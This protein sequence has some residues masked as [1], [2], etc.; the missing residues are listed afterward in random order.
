LRDRL[1]LGCGADYR[2]EFWNVDVG[3]FEVDEVADVFE[4][5][6]WP[7]GVFVEL[8]ALDILEHASW[9]KLEGIFRE[10]VRVLAVGGTVEVRVPDMREICERYVRGEFDA[11]RA[12]IWLYGGQSAS[13]D[14]GEDWDL[15]AHHSGFDADSLRQLAE[16]CGVRVDVL[17]R[18]DTNLRLVGVKSA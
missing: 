8:I 15:N 13:H 11:W 14:V 5:L 2:S 3:P 4:P 12:A 6:P 17:E 7:D 1:N 18:L 9:P 10:W 16:R